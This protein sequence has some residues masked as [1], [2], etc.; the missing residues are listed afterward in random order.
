LT[1]LGKRLHVIQVAQSIAAEAHRLVKRRGSDDPYILHPMRVSGY[2]AA[3][4]ECRPEMLAA[5]YLHDVVED[6]YASSTDLL[7]RLLRDIVDVE[8]QPTV[9]RIVYLVRRLT[10]DVGCDKA[11]YLVSVCTDYDATLIKLADRL[12]NLSEG[13]SLGEEWFRKYA[14][15]TREFLPHAARTVGEQHPLWTAVHAKVSDRP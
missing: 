4:G 9:Y 10:R 14:R 13:E 11:A 5:A 7:Y 15:Q 3:I 8:L 12:D 2:L 1:Q 6:F